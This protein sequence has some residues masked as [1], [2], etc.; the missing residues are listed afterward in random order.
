MREEEDFVK[1]KGMW[2]EK[3]TH[4]MHSEMLAAA[5]SA[6]CTNNFTRATGDGGEDD[7]NIYPFKKKEILFRCSDIAILPLG[8]I[9]V[10]NKISI[11]RSDFGM[12]EGLRKPLGGIMGSCI[13]ACKQ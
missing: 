2:R 10:H 8:N 13:K 12:D 6:I 7:N 1:V 9:V 4:F 3:T 11:G 5:V